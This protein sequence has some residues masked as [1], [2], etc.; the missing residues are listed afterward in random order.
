MLTLH[1][2]PFHPTLE[3]L[4]IQH[5]QK[6]KVQPFS[7]VAIVAPSQRLVERLQ[8]LVG[9]KNLS[10]INVHF[11]TFSTLA[12]S[13][14]DEEG[15]LEK[16]ILSDPLFFDTLVK[17]IVKEDR[18]F[19]G[20]S[21]LVVPQGFP[22]QIRGTIRDLVDAGIPSQGPSILDAIKED[23][24]GREVDLAWLLQLLRFYQLYSDRVENLPSIQPR[25]A[26]LKKAIERAPH[27]TYLKQFDE[28][29]YYGFYDLTGLQKD[30]FEAVVKYH[31][32]RLFYPYVSEHT[33][34]AF[35]KSFRDTVLL[36]LS[37]EASQE[38]GLH[39]S[40]KEE[41][42]EF[43]AKTQDI[44]IFNCSGVRDEAWNVANEIIRFHE[45]ENIPYSKM[46]VVARSQ[47]RFR[48]TWI[49]LL[50][51]KNIPFSASVKSSLA[52]SP[53]VEHLLQ[54]LSCT[55]PE[56]ANLMEKDFLVRTDFCLPQGIENFDIEEKLP[57]LGLWSEMVRIS[58]DLLNQYFKP[59]DPESHQIWTY[60]MDGLK[61][62]GRF[63]LLRSKVRRKDFLETL[64]ERWL[65]T[66]IPLSDSS[67]LGVSL[68]HAEAARGLSFDVIFLVGIE[69]RVFPRILRE[70]PFL[71]DEARFQLNR[72]G[73]KISQKL[74]AL[75]EEKLLFH[76]L[77]QSATKSIFLSYQRSDE[78][79]NLV[80][81]S[82]FL[83]AFVENNGLNMDSDS[84]SLPRPTHAKIMQ[85]HPSSLGMQDVVFRYLSAG[86][87]TS[88]LQYLRHL[89]ENE[90]GLEE[91]LKFLAD[92][93]SFG[94][95]GPIDGRISSLEMKDI[96]PNNLVSAT[97]LE[98]FGRC[99]FQFYVTKILGLKP[100]EIDIIGE[101]MPADKKGT[102]V[103]DF[104]ESFYRGW[105]DEERDSIH[106]FPEAYFG[107]VFKKIFGPVTHKDMLVHPVLWDI[108][109]SLLEQDLRD[110]LR[111]DLQYLSDNNLKPAF[112]EEEII[113]Q[114]E[115]PL[116]GIQWFGKPDRVDQGK[117]SVRILD[118]KTG[119]ISRRPLLASLQGL[120]IQPALYILLVQHH[121]ASKGIR[122]DKISFV[123][124]RLG[125]EDR[126]AELTYEDWL[127][128]K[129]SIMETI[130]TQMDLIKKGE[131]LILPDERYC[132][133][134]EVQSVCHKNHGPSAYRAK[135][136]PGMT[137]A[138]LRSK[139]L[140]SVEKKTNGHR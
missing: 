111:R 110:F 6:L 17:M 21:D 66:E 135:K 36:A 94:E 60:L 107:S 45:D 89:K 31:P 3:V 90:V 20:L 70:D 120:K 11:H 47:D 9:K 14:V 8:L 22:P 123:Y 16:T 29:L 109:R 19:P 63:D 119:Q 77:V 65:T 39:D 137:L 67:P 53:L 5:L 30:F 129:K 49:S 59:Q 46:A 48:D 106:R 136:G 55:D 1:S 10:F 75:E 18:P 127:C 54:F 91:G 26:I 38:E 62:M 92:F 128:Y 103:H 97:R 132:Q 134:C 12:Q 58:V 140:S 51:Q 79:G 104:F 72:L 98:I 126:P 85:A 73:Y 101:E 93:Q 74:P 23:Y 113:S 118:Y 124:E 52:S 57:G 112:F 121:L 100:L 84:H 15:G 13:L 131:F 25:S 7:P 28:I 41:G 24:L 40:A 76:L 138:A 27:S 68:L 108:Y 115:S 139:K 37:K 71:R 44:H 80:G 125:G 133:W 83:R 2:G 4:F 87:S 102:L 56:I 34:Y 96:F 35:A 122:P 50:R 81:P 99:P 32:A 86:D 88:A 82:S 61:D 95:P 64:S 42:Q 69:E 78:E 105:D 43:K 114:L 33:A 116:D 130:Q 117:D